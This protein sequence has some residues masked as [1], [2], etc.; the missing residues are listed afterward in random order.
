MLDG[1]TYSFGE[2]YGAVLIGLKKDN[3]EFFSPIP[4]Q[5]IALSNVPTQHPRQFLEYAI[6]ERMTES[7]VYQFKVVNV[8]HESGSISLVS[9]SPPDFGIHPF[10]EVPSVEEAGESVMERKILEMQFKVFQFVHLTFQP[11]KRPNTCPELVK[12]ERF[13]DVL[14]RADLQPVQQNVLL[15]GLWRNRQNGNPLGFGMGFDFAAES[16]ALILNGVGIEN[17]KIG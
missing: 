2:R 7:V 12:V 5:K 1:L 9:A 15:N 6:A 16:V 11:D 13:R 10:L 3:N 4:C 8:Y 14:L 17:N